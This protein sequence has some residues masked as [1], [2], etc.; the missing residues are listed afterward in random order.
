MFLWPQ[1]INQLRAFTPLQ[2]PMSMSG[3]WETFRSPKAPTFSYDPETFILPAAEGCGL[4]FFC[5]IT[6]EPR[7]E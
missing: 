2:D 7:L 4:L 3:T 5:F 6:L 1:N